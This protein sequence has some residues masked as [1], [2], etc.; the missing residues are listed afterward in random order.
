M[1][2]KKQFAKAKEDI[3]K[4]KGI[5]ADMQIYVTEHQI[6]IKDDLIDDEKLKISMEL[7]EEDMD[8]R[9]KGAL[10]QYVNQLKPKIK[11][12][13]KITD[14]DA[15]L[16]SKVNFNEFMKQI[17][18]MDNSIQVVQN[19]IEHKIP[20]FRYEIETQLAYKPTMDQ[21]NKELEKKADKEVVDKMLDRLNQFD[22][23]M[24]K[25]GGQLAEANGEDE[26]EVD[27]HDP[28]NLQGAG[29]GGEVQDADA[30]FN[31]AK[32]GVAGSPTSPGM[33]KVTTSVGG[34]GGA[35]KKQIEEL[36]N[37][38]EDSKKE[39]NEKIIELN[40]KISDNMDTLVKKMD[41]QSFEN[42]RVD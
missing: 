30:L 22:D 7:L 6:R 18:R 42:K 39:L 36:K 13:L 33:K 17:E 14:L 4:I 35:N 37:M 10:E 26:E 12:R 11:K 23:T 24:K 34:G 15:K 5:L 21:V 1:L 29:D 41:D 38:I 40:T 20:A 2:N 27:E 25:I 31:Q 28:D 8:R 9:M 19:V 32:A 16:S 3:K